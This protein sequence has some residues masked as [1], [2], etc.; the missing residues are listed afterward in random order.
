[1]TWSTAVFKGRVC[2]HNKTRAAVT[3]AFSAA[4]TGKTAN[5]RAF[6]AEIKT[7]LS[8]HTKLEKTTRETRAGGD[9]GYKKDGGFAQPAHVLDG[10]AAE[11]ARLESESAASGLA[12][13]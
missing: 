12:V 13:R 1:M 5:S 6:A 11:A 2:F 4:P 3:D 9:S 10:E 8:T 7:F